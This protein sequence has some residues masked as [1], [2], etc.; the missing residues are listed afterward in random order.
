MFSALPLI[1]DIA[2][3][4]M[5]ES[6]LGCQRLARQRLRDHYVDLGGVEGALVMIDQRL[7]ECEHNRLVLL[8]DRQSI[9][10]AVLDACRTARVGAA[11]DPARH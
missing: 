5:S 8:D 4:P 1:T 10:I 11:D 6:L 2:Q 7:C 9:L 3:Q